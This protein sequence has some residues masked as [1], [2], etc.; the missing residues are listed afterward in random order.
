MIYWQQLAT[1]PDDFGWRI[2]GRMPSTFH[3]GEV[4]P[5]RVFTEKHLVKDGVHLL[6]QLSALVVACLAVAF[7]VSRWAYRSKMRKASKKGNP[8]ERGV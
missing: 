1:A 5:I 6:L 4:H 8:M 3:S 2:C 7:L